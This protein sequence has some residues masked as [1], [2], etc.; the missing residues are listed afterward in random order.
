MI[1]QEKWFLARVI[2][3]K[4]LYAFFGV[5]LLAA[6]KIDTYSGNIQWTINYEWEDKSLAGWRDL[7]LQDGLDSREWLNP[8]DLE[9]A[10][11]LKNW[12]KF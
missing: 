10:K 6:K 8:S 2:H 3:A 5:P 12:D 1:G 4:H 7:V 9:T 11:H